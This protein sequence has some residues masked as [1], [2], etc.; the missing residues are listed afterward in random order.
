MKTILIDCH[1]HTTRYSGCSRLSPASMCRVAVERGLDGVV[2]T[3]HQIQWN[4]EEIK[5]LQREFPR[6]KIYAGLEITLEEGIDLVII[7]PNRAIEVPFLIPFKRFWNGGYIDPEES[8]VFVA[9]LFR[10]QRDMGRGVEEVLSMVDG[11]EMNSINILLAGYLFSEDFSF[12]RPR[13]WF[14]YEEVL[15]RF[16]LVPLFNTDAH[17][18]EVIGA[19]ANELEV[20]GL[21]P[22]EE[23]LARVLKTSTPRQ[24][25]NISL[26]KGF[27]LS[28]SML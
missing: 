15:Q 26:L 16:D 9:H 10:W 20:E 2:I 18:E 24:Y 25:Q 23:G 28:P 7:S 12:I 13:H 8:F 21:P 1:V 4:P 3:E 6:I 19:V 11:L 5:E 14:L 17:Q 22:D 27:F